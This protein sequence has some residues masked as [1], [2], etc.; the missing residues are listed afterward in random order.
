MVKSK[1]S[2]NKNNVINIKNK[3]LE[4]E[5]SQRLRKDGS[6]VTAEPLSKRELAFCSFERDISPNAKN[7]RYIQVKL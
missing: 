6:Q 2:P 3:V 4:L 5:L 7:A 1:G